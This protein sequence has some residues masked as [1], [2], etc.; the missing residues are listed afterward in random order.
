MLCMRYLVLWG[1]RVHCLLAGSLV[2][3]H[4]CIKEKEFKNG[5]IL[6]DLKYPMSGCEQRNLFVVMV[7]CGQVL[8]FGF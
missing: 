7:V 5:R 8:G 6:R 3:A 4:R 1:R 2:F